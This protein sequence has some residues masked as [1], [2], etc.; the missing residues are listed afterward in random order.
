ML[1][2]CSHTAWG[3]LTLTSFPL[4]GEADSSVLHLIKDGYML[5]KQM[6]V[7]NKTLSSHCFSWG[8]R[9]WRLTQSLQKK[10]ER[11]SPTAKKMNEMVEELYSIIRLLPALQYSNAQ[12]LHSQQ[13]RPVVFEGSLVKSCASVDVTPGGSETDCT[14]PKV[15]QHFEAIS[16]LVMTW[17]WSKE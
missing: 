14:S 17:S 5:R 15:W 7:E 13:R 4:R 2:W 12:K 16:I 11:S 9:D 8:H 10:T 1:C 3:Q 6:Y